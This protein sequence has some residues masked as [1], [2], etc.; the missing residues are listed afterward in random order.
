MQNGQFALAIVPQA[1][2]CFNRREGF[3]LGDRLMVS[4]FNGAENNEP[5]TE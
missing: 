5:R 4:P 1:G 3:L 2:V